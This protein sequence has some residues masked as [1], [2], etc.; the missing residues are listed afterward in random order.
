MFVV[1]FRRG[2]RESVTQQIPMAVGRAAGALNPM[3]DK[4]RRYELDELSRPRGAQ[5]ATRTVLQ[6]R[7]DKQNGGAS[8]TL[9]C[10]SM[11]FAPFGPS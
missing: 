4:D 8:G 7:W 1:V 11:L 9:I 3:R 2:K 5:I 6:V 10:Q